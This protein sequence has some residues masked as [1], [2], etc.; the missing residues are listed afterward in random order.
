MVQKFM[1]IKTNKETIDKKFP[2]FVF[3]YTDF[4][5]GRADPL[6]KEVKISNSEKQIQEIFDAYI[7]ENVKKGWEKV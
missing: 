1:V 7:S 2:A 3:H 5:S 4:S 6:Q